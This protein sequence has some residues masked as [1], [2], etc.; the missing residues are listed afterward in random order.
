MMNNLLQY[1]LMRLLHVEI[2]EVSLFLSQCTM[3]HEVLLLDLP[4][5]AD[6]IRRSA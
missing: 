6:V 1:D 5:W 4:L 3:R 2:H